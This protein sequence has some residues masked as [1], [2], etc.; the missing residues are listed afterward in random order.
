MTPDTKICEHCGATYRRRTGSSAREWQARRY[1]SISCGAR[2]SHD[3][4]EPKRNCRA[5]G[6]ELRRRDN[7]G[8]SNWHRRVYCDHRCAQTHAEAKRRATASE[9]GDTKCCPQCNKT[10]S[11]D[12]LSTLAWNRKIYCSS[13]CGA[14]KGHVAGRVDL[15]DAFVQ[16]ARKSGDALLKYQMRLYERIA[17]QR[18]LKDW[19]EAAVMCGMRA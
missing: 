17:E 5:C 6:T 9:L 1:C 13:A 19:A 7:E 18:G 3:R 11:R 8:S 16:Q 2:A 14:A 10:F 15:P 4:R 12:G